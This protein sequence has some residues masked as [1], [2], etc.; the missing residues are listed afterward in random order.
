MPDNMST[1]H[2]WHKEPGIYVRS[3]ADF[4]D[5]WKHFRKFTRVQDE[6]GKWYYFRFW[7]QRAFRKIPDVLGEETGKRLFIEDMHFIWS[8]YK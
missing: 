7:E 3:R 5:L 4:E 8:Y 6:S 1:V 2:L